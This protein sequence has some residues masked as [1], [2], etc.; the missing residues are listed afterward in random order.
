MIKTILITENE[1]GC[2]LAEEHGFVSK[3]KEDISST[4]NCVEKLKDE[5]DIYYLLFEGY[6]NNSPT[7]DMLNLAEF[8]FKEGIDTEIISITHSLKDFLSKNG[9]EAFLHLLD[10]GLDF[11]EFK[12]DG[13]KDIPQKQRD[14]QIRAEIFPLLSEVDSFKLEHYLSFM[15]QIF[16]LKFPPGFVIFQ[17]VP[18][19]CNFV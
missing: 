9:N 7:Q 19:F 15:K 11:V 12:I 17:G 5:V 6:K 4:E 3:C 16:K 14:R 2:K 1:S 18:F 8:M 13:M 10:D